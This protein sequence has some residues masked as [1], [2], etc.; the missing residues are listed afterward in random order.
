LFTET[1]VL[2]L[3]AAVSVVDTAFA[4]PDFGPL[5]TING[6]AAGAE[7][8]TSSAAASATESFLLARGL[9][10][11][12]EGLVACEEVG[13]VALACVPLFEFALVVSEDGAA[14]AEF[15]AEVFAGVAG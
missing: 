14:V 7:F 8:S 15:E 3:G 4:A 2:M 5:F 6:C 11:F 12:P 9:A 13:A 1:I 10:L